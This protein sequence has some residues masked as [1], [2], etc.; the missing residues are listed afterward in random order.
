MTQIDSY[1]GT[2]RWQFA[3][4]GYFRVDR[5]PDGRWMLVTP[6]G[7]GFVTIAL[8]HAEDVNL[9][10]D[11]NIDVWRTKYGADRE[12]WIRRGVVKDMA[13]WNF[14]TLGY[15]V[16]YVAGAWEA[17][18]WFGETAKTVD[19]GHTSYKSWSTRDYKTANRPYCLQLRALEIEDWNHYPAYRDVATSDFADYIDSMARDIAVDHADSDNLLG[20][21]FVDV[22]GWA[23]HATG[24]DFAALRGLDPDAR[25]V[26]LYDVASK[27]YDVVA[28]AIRRYDANH[29]LLGDRYNGNKH[30]PRSVLDAMKPFVDVLSVQYFPANNDE[31]HRQMR[32]DFARWQAVV[33]KPVLNADI[34]NWCPTELNP[35]RAS[36]CGDQAGRARDY[37]GAISTIIDQ[38][39]FIGWHWCAHVENPGRGW[40]IKDCHDQSYEAFRVPVA[41]FN[42]RVYDMID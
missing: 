7:N 36:E 9:K 27:Y 24:N 38:P 42:A 20:Y 2:D 37:I 26:K 10:H 4:T 3:P 15:T 19:L 30:I 16:D 35:N 29:L 23:P 31:G 40:G 25:D 17:L 14:N 11:Y 6:D 12:T 5:R 1:G 32:D 34:G 13:D 18:N 28:S 22:P 33:D 8:N 41:D 21:F 39:W